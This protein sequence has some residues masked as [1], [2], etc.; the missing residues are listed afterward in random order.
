MNPGG[1]AGGFSL[2]GGLLSR[3]DSSTS[4]CVFLLADSSALTYFSFVCFDYILHL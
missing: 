1:P 4:C 2:P 3:A